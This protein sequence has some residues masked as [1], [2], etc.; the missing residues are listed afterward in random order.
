ME[1]CAHIVTCVGFDVCAQGL[2]LDCTVAQY[3]CAAKC[4]NALDCGSLTIQAGQAC[5]SQCAPQDAG[6]PLDGGDPC[7]NA[8][9]HVQQCLG[10][11]ACALL[12]MQL[13]CS[14]PQNA[15]IA[16]CVSGTQCSQLSQQTFQACQA[17]CQGPP[18]GPDAG[19]AMACQQC[20]TQSCG[21]AVGAC[22]ANMACQGWL[23][24][25]GACQQG[26]QG[27]QCY[28]SCDMQFAGAAALYNPVYACSCS[29]CSTA[30]SAIDPCAHVP[31]AGP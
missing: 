12:G 22:G 28:F 14:T 5:L 27:P 10:F 7:T 3:E 24:C 19:S 31:D 17:Q 4:I 30:C 1:A 2:K 11:D 16:D 25:V 15:C 23:G 29:S 18:P 8:C 6:P 21:A 26:S 9:G 13:D 20:S